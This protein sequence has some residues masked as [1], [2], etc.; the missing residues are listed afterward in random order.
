MDAP[1][2]VSVKA[3]TDG[4]RKK[5]EIAIARCQRAKCVWRSNDPSI[6]LSAEQSGTA[7]S[8]TQVLSA[9]RGTLNPNHQHICKH[10]EEFNQ[11]Q[12]PNLSSKQK[13][14]QIQSDQL[15]NGCH[16]EL[17]GHIEKHLRADDVWGFPCVLG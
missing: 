10:H 15:S 7:P 2:G 11:G 5:F 13:G 3:S 12:E 9:T 4:R 16:Q 6:V 14:H 1:H 17:D 8:S